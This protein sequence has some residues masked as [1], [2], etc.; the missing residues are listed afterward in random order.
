M[1]AFH[2]TPSIVPLFS[3]PDLLVALARHSSGARRNRP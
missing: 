3:M 2:V 1:F